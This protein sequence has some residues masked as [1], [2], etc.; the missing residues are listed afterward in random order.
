MPLNPDAKLPS[1]AQVIKPKSL[2]AS[3]SA[4]RKAFSTNEEEAYLRTRCFHI[5]SKQM[6]NAV[7]DV[8]KECLSPC[9]ASLE[10]FLDASLP[11]A[12]SEDNA[13][14]IAVEAQGPSRK[15]P[16]MSPFNSTTH[17][18]MEGLDI[19]LFDRQQEDNAQIDLLLL[20]VAV[21]QQGPSF[22]L[23]RQEQVQHLL[24]Y[25][26]ESRPRAAVVQLKEPRTYRSRA[27]AAHF[28]RI[29]MQELVRECHQ[30][31]PI[32][33]TEPLRRRILRRKKKKASSFSDLLILWAQHVTCLDEIVVFL[34]VSM[35]LRLG[36]HV[37]T[38]ML[39]AFRSYLTFFKHFRRETIC[40]VPSCKTFY[41]C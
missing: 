15:R 39:E 16:R 4:K 2:P 18:L 5:L 38:Q 14:N 22:G 8:M 40:T 7:Q 24:T 30:Q 3:S 33:A 28:Q 34:D 6:D 17:P 37:A 35:I 36:L 23:D 19:A 10:S 25:L 26:R 41:I 27:S 32:L 9:I 13:A 12:R 1:W 31:Y 21:L 29:M 11:A 20:P